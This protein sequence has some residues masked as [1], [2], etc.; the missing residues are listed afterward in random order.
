M[1]TTIKRYNNKKG[2]AIF[3]VL[4]I[5]V[6]LGA[7]MVQFHQNSRQAQNTVHRFQTSEMARQLASAGQEEAFDYLY[8]QTGDV[9]D[10]SFNLKDIPRKVIEKNA[11]IDMTSSG[12]ASRNSVRG[13]DLPVPATRQLAEELMPGR[14]E[15]TATA[16]IV[17]FRNTDYDG[18]LFYDKEGI[19]TIEIV[20]TAKAKDEFK[21]QFPGSCT[22]VRHHDY[23][24]VS[25][26]TNKENRENSYSGSSYL[27]YALFIRKGQ[28]EFES[29]A[30]GTS[31][32]PENVSL[33]IDA[34]STPGKVNLGSYGNKYTF[35]NT[36][37]ETESMV[38]NAGKANTITEL[39][40][41]GDMVDKIYPY[42]RSQ[43]KKQCK[44]QDADLDSLK[45]HKA[46]FEHICYPATDEYFTNEELKNVRIFTAVDAVTLGKNV[47][48]SGSEAV[49]HPGIKI[50]PEE[51]LSD[52]LESDVRKQYI[53]IGYFKLD[54]TDCELTVSADG[55]GSKTLKVKQDAPQLIEN[56]HNAK[57]YCFDNTYSSMYK[58]GAQQVDP[59]AL[60]SYIKS[61]GEEIASQAFSHLNDEF[62]YGPGNNSPN[63]NDA[64]FFAPSNSESPSAITD[65]SDAHY[66]Y[67]HF[68]LWNKRLM[69]AEDLEQMGIYDKA[70]HRLHL[71]GIVHCD[72]SITLGDPGSDL[73]VDG[74]G[75]IIA[76]GIIIEGAIKKENPQDVCVLFARDG[77]IKVK[78]SKEIEAALMAMGMSNKTSSITSNEQL[79][80]KGSIATDLLLLSQWKNG[81][82]HKITYDD[83]LAPNKDIYQ[84]NISKWV[85]FERVIENE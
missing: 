16:R 73:I 13:L 45:G 72:C 85:S 43:V 50:K 23:K 3:M 49:F 36:S 54:L 11:D 52:I 84:I 38:P 65:P 25:I 75:V 22:I 33:E 53:N 19:G 14:M 83:A 21:H 9:Y 55:A 29:G 77:F 51:K 28:D 64:K 17:D 40:A 31:I 42:F 63:G 70:N 46:I 32:N 81:V 5:M 74:C 69:T 7:L 18:N 12:P 76:S 82:T 6:V 26:V 35:L 24:V 27:D 79:N 48:I 78:T 56:F 57:I 41:E 20:V 37:K 61:K 44:D 67:S 15:I 80:L 66:P 47:A 68:N 2:I 4:F 39:C 71:R 10:S 59:S 8:K 1:G 30:M 34:G 58:S 62:A 60:T